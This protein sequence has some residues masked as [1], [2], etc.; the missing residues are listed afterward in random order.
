MPFIWIINIAFAGIPL[1]IIFLKYKK[2]IKDFFSDPA[3]NKLGILGMDA[4]GKTL[5]LCF[6]RGVPYHE[7]MAKTAVNDEYKSFIFTTSSGDKINVDSGFDIPGMSDYRIKYHEIMDKSDMIFYFFDI[8]RYF[9]EIDYQRE[10]NS[11]F[12]YL[13]E[14]FEKKSEKK[15]LIFG[16]HLDKCKED[17]N[18]VLENLRKLIREKPYKGLIEKITPINLT[19]KEELIK[20]TDLI[21]KK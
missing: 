14:Y 20:I 18:K 19:N 16:S 1:L 10:C 9:D 8:N 11:R 12:L 15:L 17:K 3:K 13:N 21:F 6:L 2:N 7:N 4:A 5:F